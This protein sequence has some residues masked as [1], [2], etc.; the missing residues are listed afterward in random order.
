MKTI[1]I[2]LLAHYQS[3]DSKTLCT[4]WKVTLTNGTIHTYT[5]H[6]QDVPFEGLVYG[7]ASGY[8]PSAIDSSAE[9]NPDNL[10]LEGFLQATSI[11]EGDLHSGK[12]DY[13]YVEIFEVNFMD[14]TMGRNILRAGTLGEVKAGRTKFTAELR[15]LMQSYTKT[16]V[17]LTS[18]ECNADLGDARCKKD[19]TAF[20]YGPMTVS[21][22]SGDS[23]VVGAAGLTAYA[24]NWFTGGVVT[25]LSGSNTGVVQEVQYSAQA[26]GQILFFQQP[27]F[28]PKVGD[29]FTILA[30]CTKR[31]EE[32]CIAKF[33]NGVNFQG[34][35]HVPQ[36][37]AYKVGTN[38]GVV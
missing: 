4:C 29:T 22:V 24:D 2:A 27:P 33:A 30:G 26:V 28:Q 11:T 25:W 5:D 7:A 15:G 9:L 13:A 17:R 19:V 3:G 12:W 36:A 37:D 38:S 1:P 10:Q 18:K 6:D 14:P 32:D 21:V 31:F 16:I 35:P 23:R 8:T 34:F 20:T